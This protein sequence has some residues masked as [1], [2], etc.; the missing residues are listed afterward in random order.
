MF[1]RRVFRVR[2][3]EEEEFDHNLQELPKMSFEDFQKAWKSDK[4]KLLTSKSVAGVDSDYGYRNFVV[5]L[6]EIPGDKQ[7]QRTKWA[8]N[9]TENQSQT[10]LE[11]Y[12]GPQYEIEKH[13]TNSFIRWIALF[14]WCSFI[15]LFLIG[16]DNF[17]EKER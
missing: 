15:I 17:I 13:T 2:L 7:L 5:D 16:N 3:S 4:I 10:L 11:E 9:L 12:R 6:K 1:R 14:G 8:M